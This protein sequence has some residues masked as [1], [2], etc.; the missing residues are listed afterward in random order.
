MEEEQVNENML[1]NLDLLISM[2]VLEEQEFWDEL[3]NQAS[4]DE[5]GEEYD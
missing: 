5:L 1:A 4:F 2:D 3:S